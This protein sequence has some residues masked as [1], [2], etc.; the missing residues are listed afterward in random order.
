[1]FGFYIRKSINQGQGCMHKKL[2]MYKLTR[3]QSMFCQEHIINTLLYFCNIVCN[4]EIAENSN[5]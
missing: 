1:M 3:I 2:Q 5:Y 4:A